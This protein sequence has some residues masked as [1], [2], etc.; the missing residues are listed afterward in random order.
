MISYMKQGNLGSYRANHQK[1]YS[2][3]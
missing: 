3:C 2:N 1:R